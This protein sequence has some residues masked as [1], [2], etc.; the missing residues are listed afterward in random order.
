MATATKIITEQKSNTEIPND[1]SNA[2]SCLTKEGVNIK[3][4]KRS[5]IAKFMM[6]QFVDVLMERCLVTLQMTREL[7]ITDTRKVNN[8]ALV[9]ITFVG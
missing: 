1:A 9:K 3:V 5:Q 4:I 2:E 7:P 8:M 6:R